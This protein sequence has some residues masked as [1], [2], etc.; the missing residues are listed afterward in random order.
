MGLPLK[1]QN[2]LGGFVRGFTSQLCPR[3]GAPPHPIS[4]IMNYD[5]YEMNHGTPCT[6]WNHGMR[7][8]DWYI[9]AYIRLCTHSFY[10]VMIDRCLLARIDS[11]CFFF[12]IARSV[13]QTIPPIKPYPVKQPYPRHLHHMTTH[14]PVQD[15][16][17]AKKGGNHDW[18]SCFI[19][20]PT[21]CLYIYLGKGNRS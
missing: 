8:F 12:L 10:V 18:R 3:D 20:R 7:C 1:D 13:T 21:R 2:R 5:Y 15:G 4:K 19:K 14:P 9:N 16:K 6:Q 11:S 17:K